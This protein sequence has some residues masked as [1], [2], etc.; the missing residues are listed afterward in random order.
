MNC[1]FALASGLNPTLRCQSAPSLDQL[2]HE[3]SR[4]LGNQGEVKAS[5]FSKSRIQ[6]YPRS[7]VVH[8]HGVAK[9]L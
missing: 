9:T 8:T 5:E 1:G 2:A 3:T 4:F 7:L 6:A